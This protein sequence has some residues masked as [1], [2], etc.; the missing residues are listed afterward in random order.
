MAGN[1]HTM[2][3]LALLP[4][5]LLG[6]SVWEPV[7]Y[8]LRGG[9]HHVI[10]LY[11]GIDTPNTAADVMAVFLSQLPGEDLALVPD[12]IPRLYI[13]TLCSQRSV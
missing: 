4:N 2:T 5:P 13:P 1:G 10:H 9:D 8:R 3:A 7:P 6:N 12:S 11:L